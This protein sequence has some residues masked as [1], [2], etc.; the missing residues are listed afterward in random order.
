MPDPR[1]R[2]LLSVSA[3]HRRRGVD[4]R[5]SSTTT[6]RGPRQVRTAPTKPRSLQSI[7]RQTIAN[8]V[9]QR[10]GLTSVNTR[11]VSQAQRTA[12]RS[13]RLLQRQ[14]KTF[15][16][17]AT[18][19]MDTIVPGAWVRHA[20]N[21]S[22][23][24]IAINTALDIAFIAPFLRPAGAAVR[25]ATRSTVRGATAGARVARA[26]QQSIRA[27]AEAAKAAG[28]RAGDAN[29]AANA[30]V[31]VQQALA[32]GNAA[33]V[34]SAGRNLEQ[35]GRAIN[36]RALTQRGRFLHT[37]A[38]TVSKLASDLKK[39][40]TKDIRTS[41]GRGKRPPRADLRATS[42]PSR[43]ELAKATKAAQGAQASAFRSISNAQ[44]TRLTEAMRVIR[45]GSKGSALRDNLARTTKAVR[46][47][48][49]RGTRAQRVLDQVNK[50]NISKREK[51][52]FVRQV[53]DGGPLT[54]TLRSLRDATKKAR[55]GK[56]AA[57]RRA[58]FNR[59][60]A[61][62]A[63]SKPKQPRKGGTKQPSTLE[64]LR[65]GV[66]RV[67]S[68]E[69][70]KAAERVGRNERTKIPKLKDPTR[71]KSALGIARE[72]KKR[73]EDFRRRPRGAPERP[74]K[75]PEPSGPKKTATKVAEP[76]KPPA[77]P[78]PKV[79]V[80]RS[81]AG[82]VGRPGVQ[83]PDAISPNRGPGGKFKPT[84]TE[85][86]GPTVEPGNPITPAPTPTPTPGPTP[87]TE[88][89]PRPRP[90]D[91]PPAPRPEPGPPKDDPNPTP[92]IP[93]PKPDDDPDPAPD[94]K[95]T[96]LGVPDDSPTP[97][98]DPKPDPSPKQSRPP[99]G[100]TGTG[101]RVGKPGK[102]RVRLEPSFTLP[103]GT[104]PPGVFPRV[105]RWTQG[106]VEITMNV[107]NGRRSFKA[108]KTPGSPRQTFKVV[109]ES[110]RRPKV[111]RTPLGIVS[112]A[113]DS[114]GLR[115]TRRP[116]TPKPFR[117]RRGL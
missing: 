66:R 101:E 22:T 86:N 73:V 75:P 55:D 51:N 59:A 42:R 85:G 43:A 41:I 116:Q 39:P 20:G 38:E 102:F 71:P 68:A 53:L 62:T 7:A 105:V 36:S 18:R 84:P 21:M 3:P 50:A 56:R 11:Q 72:G 31:R 15:R 64:V 109:E 82:V 63:R 27:I 93:G 23:K 30:T 97:K 114:D 61:R 49:D 108:V 103:R 95:P 24:D 117:R 12:D 26:P 107:Q 8:D 52:A 67:R 106:K 57:D 70:I 19:T 47:L 37:Q 54:R 2:P 65:S 79:K 10:A 94:P 40:P 111:G 100:T 45:S 77:S 88:P 6:V 29:R 69:D 46:R 58:D 92:R 60:A 87:Q 33:R 48:R 25:G 113:I 16:E 9:R 17:A 89:G 34:A 83:L 14:S 98:P 78:P 110:K 44:Q 104:L 76:P 99:V 96:P 81:R 4:P 13:A 5:P 80:P 91:P 28:D 115:F 90:V 1:P 74:L 112:I 32:S 35:A